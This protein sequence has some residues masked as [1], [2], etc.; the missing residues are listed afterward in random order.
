M[1]KTTRSMFV[2][3]LFV[4][5]LP[6]TSERRRMLDGTF[7]AARASRHHE[8]QS[9]QKHR[10]KTIGGNASGRRQFPTSA[11]TT[12]LVAVQTQCTAT[13]E[14]DKVLARS[15]G[16]GPS[17]TRNRWATNIYSRTVMTAG[18]TWHV[19]SLANPETLKTLICGH[20]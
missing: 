10:P 9:I 4:A 19:S 5:E 2:S 12:V 8:C 3:C 18:C 15:G 7:G 1:T 14:V 20:F 11:L 16:P 6:G 13:P 17:E